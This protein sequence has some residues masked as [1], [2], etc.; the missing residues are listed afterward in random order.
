MKLHLLPCLLFI[1]IAFSSCKDTSVKTAMKKFPGFTKQQMEQ[2]LWTKEQYCIPFDLDTAEQAKLKKSTNGKC[3]IPLPTW[4]PEGFTVEDI[5]A[6]LGKNLSSDSLAVTILYSKKLANGKKQAFIIETRFEF[7]D[8]PYSDPIFI[9]SALG[10]I[11]LFYEPVDDSIYTDP[12]GWGKKIKNCAITDLIECD[13]A[14]YPK[15]VY[16]S[17]DEFLAQDNIVSKDNFEMIPFE[18]TKKIIASMQKL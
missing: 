8:L 14:A 2:M 17:I 18:D 16:M 1:T 15:Y 10:N 13:S 3:A 12:E 5:D 6:N 4:L 9:T 7:G 11:C